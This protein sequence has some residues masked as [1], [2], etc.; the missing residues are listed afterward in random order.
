[1]LTEVTAPLKNVS[2]ATFDGL[3]V[4]LP[5]ARARMRCCEASVRSPTMST[6][7]RWR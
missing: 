5:A 2:I 6:N 1:M 3:M 7:S 4:D